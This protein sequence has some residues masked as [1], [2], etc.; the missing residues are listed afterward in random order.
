VVTAVD[1]VGNVVP[2]YTGSVRFTSS[3]PGATLPANYTFTA[4]DNGSR[5]FANVSLRS[6]GNQTI[7][8]IELGT[9]KPAGGDF[10]IEVIAGPASSMQSDGS[11][12]GGILAGSP[13]SL[14][15]TLSD[16]YGNP[17]N[18]FAGLVHFSSTDPLAVL[19]ANYNFGQ[20]DRSTHV[21]TGIVL[22]SAGTQTVTVTAT[23]AV[24][25]QQNG[26]STLQAGRV[27]TTSPF[28]IVIVVP[29]KQPVPA[30]SR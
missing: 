17:A 29:V 22:R 7:G 11:P 27:S 21:F 20:A 15:V 28:I 19:P 23:P 30:H 9:P 25:G 24:P 26:K 12:L 1:A 3:D 8:A 14:T 6:S 2:G 13:W 18:A 5:S 10:E 16:G 4:G